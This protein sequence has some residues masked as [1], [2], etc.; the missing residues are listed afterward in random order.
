MNLGLEGWQE[1]DIGFSSDIIDEV[2]HE[3]VADLVACVKY[4]HNNKEERSSDKQ[5]L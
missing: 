4:C 5:R 1:H 2:Q 3:K